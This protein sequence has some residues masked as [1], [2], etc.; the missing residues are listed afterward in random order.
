MNEFSK[1][2]KFA[3]VIAERPKMA[4]DEEERKK[5]GDFLGSIR[6]NAR[7]NKETTLINDNV[8]L[9]PLDSG[10]RFLAQFFDLAVGKDIPLRILFLDE[11]PNW[12]QYP[13]PDEAKS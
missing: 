10:M 9:I 8:W 7:P 1:N 2:A 11:E 13:K 3:L 4:T 6:Q 12:L 5:W